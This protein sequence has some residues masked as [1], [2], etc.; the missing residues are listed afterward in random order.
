[1]TGRNRKSMPPDFEPPVPAWAAKWPSNTTR[2]TS[3]FFGAQGEPSSAW[4]EWITSSL[5]QGDHAPELAETA[6]FVD[7]KG[8][9]NTVGIAYWKNEGYK[10]WWENVQDWWQSKDRLNEGCGYWREV[11][12]VPQENIET[13]HSTPNSHGIANLAGELEGPV[14]EH[15][16]PGAARDRI[17][18]SGNDEMR[19]PDAISRKLTATRGEDR[20]LVK[21]NKFMCIIRSG[22]DW[23]RCETEERDFY[24]NEVEPSLRAGMDYLRDNPIESRCLNMRLMQSTDGDGAQLDQTFGLGYA[25]DIYAFEEWA[26]SHPTHLK[27]FDQFMGHAE[28]FGENMA[29]RLWHEVSVITGDD[30]EFEYIACHDQTGLLPYART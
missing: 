23:G 5:F 28:R 9:S 15:A 7:A 1:M 20:V 21:P 18:L 17:P 25:L 30:A 12:H 6:Q 4:Q 26:K 3:A 13:L 19:G 24:L 22:Q 29:L 2:L 27:I 8:V 11:F 14:E 16:Y 10:H